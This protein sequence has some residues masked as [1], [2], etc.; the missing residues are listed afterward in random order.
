M[1]P[2]NFDAYPRKLQTAARRV[3]TDATPAQREAMNA[4]VGHLHLHGRK[5]WEAVE[6]FRDRLV[7]V[8]V[9]DHE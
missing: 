6:R 9:H 1:P 3:D 2:P 4:R 7:H 8:H 5:P